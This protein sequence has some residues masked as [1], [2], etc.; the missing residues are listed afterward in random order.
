M[1]G[2][3]SSASFGLARW[4]ASRRVRRA[5]ELR[6]QVW[7][8]VNE[9][10]DLLAAD[11]IAAIER[12]DVELADKIRSRAADAEVQRAADRLEEVANQRLLPYPHGSLRENIKEILVAVAVIF[13]FTSFFLQLTKIPT[14]SMVPTLY[15][16]TSRD[17]ANDASFVIPGQLRRL[18]DYWFYGVSYYH[19]TARADGMLEEIE[20]PK[21][22]L[23]FVKRQRLRIGGVVVYHL[24]P[25]GSIGR[26]GSL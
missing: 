26:K 15:G 13:G 12:A 24:V 20:P 3:H 1:V 14:N 19:L 25:S 21:L 23:P 9:Q 7:R 6:R 5:T 10:R 22:V 17:Y 16:I 2:S 18:V 8:I 4:F 11:A